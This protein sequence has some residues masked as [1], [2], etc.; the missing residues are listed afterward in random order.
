MRSEEP[1]EMGL[2]LT[3]TAGWPGESM[4][5]PHDDLV[6]FKANSSITEVDIR[7]R[8]C[9]CVLRKSDVLRVSTNYK[10]GRRNKRYQGSV[11]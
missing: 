7:G 9:C 8:G 5:S 4:L 3:V 11:N 1:R 6:I 2:P 10:N